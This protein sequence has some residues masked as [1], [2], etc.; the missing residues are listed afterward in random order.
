MPQGSERADQRPRVL[1][2]GASGFLG[3]HLYGRLAGRG[4]AAAGGV[5]RPGASGLEPVD[6][7]SRQGAASLVHRLVPA[8]VVW[9]ARAA[10]PGDEAQL[11]EGLDGALGALA[12]RGRLVYVSTDGVLPGTAAPYKED[13]RPEP[14]SGTGP[15]AAYTNAKL[16]AE[17]RVL[18]AGDR[19]LVVRVGPLYGRGTPGRWDAR[20]ET[21]TDAIRQGGTVLRSTRVL[22]S[23]SHVG[24]VA[25]ALACLAVRQEVSGVL[26]LAPDEGLSYHAFA[27][28]VARA[29]ALPP[30]SVVADDTG[31][32]PAVPGQTPVRLD[33]RLDGA[34][35]RA[36]TGVALRAPEPALAGDGADMQVV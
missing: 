23:F 26:H 4:G 8:V 25:C 30:G 31:P 22:R 35:G 27:K 1:V 36:V 19:H 5:H 28:T 14:L 33:L 3:S 10:D 2:L 16:A 7:T 21:I 34:K 6:L 24:D 12:P 9:C 13:A 32:L 29:F 17:E 15:L 11:L 18:G 20:T